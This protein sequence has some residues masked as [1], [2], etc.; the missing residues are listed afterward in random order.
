MKIAFITA[1]PYGSVANQMYKIVDAATK[2]GHTCYTFSKPIKN[3]VNKRENHEFIGSTFSVKLHSFLAAYTGY[4]GLFSVCAT[5]KLI[6]RLKKIKPDVLMLLNLHGWYIN[7]PLIF[8]YI[9]KNDIKVVWRFPDFWPITGHCTGFASVECDKW[10][11]GCYDC[12]QYK[13]YPQSKVDRSKQLY[14]LKSKWFSNINNLTLVA[15]TKYLSGFIEKSFLKQY[16]CRVIYNG[17]DLDVFKPT[18]SDFRQQYGLQDKFVVLGVASDWSNRKGLDVMIK[19][20]NQLDNRFKV[21]LVGLE[22]L[23][24]D[25]NM[26]LIPAQNPS[27]LRKIYTAADVFANPTRAEAFGNVNIEALACGTPIVMFNTDGAPESIDETC[28]VVVDKN[29]IDAMQKHI[30]NICINKSLTK[31]A[32][33]KRAE[34]FEKDK[35]TNEYVKLFEEVIEDDRKSN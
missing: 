24:G 3:F 16:D 4:H 30:E 21:V 27:E 33:L 26:L 10:Q 19:L 11:T 25:H 31:E 32:C 15:I 9:K 14:K 28:G 35:R 5:L 23:D 13:E 22:K 20:S 18:P 34:F 29:D 7:L 12:P 1:L 8:N 17:V 6:R 2:S